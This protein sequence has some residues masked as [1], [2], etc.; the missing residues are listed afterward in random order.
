MTALNTPTTSF[1]LH[2]IIISANFIIDPYFPVKIS[3]VQ[4]LKRGAS[5]FVQTNQEHLHLSSY[6]CNYFIEQF[7]PFLHVKKCRFRSGNSAFTTDNNYN[8]PLMYQLC[9]LLQ[10]LYKQATS[11][12]RTESNA[13][14]TGEDFSLQAAC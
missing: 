7:Y 1:R 5:L 11:Q 2:L 10:L 4:N 3:L 12:V 14:R 6:N 8:I 9:P 13:G